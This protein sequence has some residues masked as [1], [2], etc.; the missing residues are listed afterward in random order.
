MR[1]LTLVVADIV[2]TL[3]IDGLTRMDIFCLNLISRASSRCDARAI[4]R[5][6]ED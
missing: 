6:L 5:A 1:R 2:D 3:L 4:S